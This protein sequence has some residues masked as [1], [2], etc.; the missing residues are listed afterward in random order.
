MFTQFYFHFT[1]SRP[2]KPAH[3]FFPIN[4]RKIQK[5]SLEWI[6]KLEKGSP[7]CFPAFE[8]FAFYSRKETHLGKLFG[9]RSVKYFASLKS[10]MLRKFVLRR[11][12]ITSR[13]RVAVNF[14]WRRKWDKIRLSGR[15]FQ[16]KLVYLISFTGNLGKLNRS[17][18]CFS[19][20]IEKKKMEIINRSI[21]GKLI[22]R[23]WG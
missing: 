2:K 9:L 23:F 15:D 7:A 10:R 1:N 12:S 4:S 21:R 16:R 14:S 18:E 17:I 6:S 3:R 8:Y 5:S 19:N 22:D 11:S 13:K 20:N